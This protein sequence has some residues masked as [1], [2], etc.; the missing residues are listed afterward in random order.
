[1]VEGSETKDTVKTPKATARGV[2][3]IQYP[4]LND[5][6]YGLWAVK[7]KIILRSLG[8]WGAIEGPEA[9]EEDK[10]HG[11]LAAISQAVP[12]PVMMAIA[13]KDSAKEAWDAIKE[14]SVG[15][16]RVRKARA[17]ALKRQFDGIVMEDTT[18]VHEFSQRLTSMA[19]EIRSLGGELKDS[20]IIERLF[21]A[22]PDKFL[23]II[24]TIEQWGDLTSMSVTEAVGR[25][26]VFEESLKGRRQHKEEEEHVL[27]TRAQ[28][29]ALSKEKKG[30]ESSGGGHNQGQVRGHEK[31]PQRKFDKSKIR[32]YN[33]SEYGHFASECRKPKKEKAYVAEKV[34]D[35]PVLLMLEACEQKN[36]KE[37]NC[38]DECHLEKTAQYYKEENMQLF[39]GVNESEKQNLWYLDSGATNHMTGC[40]ENFTELDTS[41]AGTVKFGDGSMVSIY[42]RGTVLLQGRMGE[43]KALTD[44][45]Y[46]PKL[47]SNIISLGQLEEQGCRIMLENGQLKV[48][49]REEQLLI[50]VKRARNRL[51]ILNL[52]VTQPICLKTHLNNEDWLWHARYGHLNFQALRTLSQKELVAGLPLVNHAEQVCSGCLVGKQRRSPFPQE[53]MFRAKEVLELVHGDLCGPIV[54]MTPAGNKFFLLMVDDYSR[55]MWIVLLKSKDMAFQAFKEIKIAAELEANAKLKAFRT[56]RGGEFRS[57]EFTSYCKQVGIKRYL[58]A[59]YSPQQ[60]GVVERRNQTVVGMAR[61]M[62]RS[63]N[64]PAKFWGEAVTTAVYILNRAITKSVVGMTP[65]EAWHKQK[66]SVHHMRTFGCIA[67][68]KQLNNQGGKFAARSTPMVFIGYE[69]GSKAYRMYDPVTGKL[70]IS[71]DAVFEEEKAWNWNTVHGSERLQG[72]EMFEI[73]EISDNC[74]QEDEAQ[75]AF[76][77]TQSVRHAENG[78]EELTARV[79]LDEPITATTQDPTEDDVSPRNNIT[80]MRTLQDLYDVTEPIEIDYSELCLLG[81]EEPADFQEA[82]K[83]ESWRCAMQDELDSIHNNN[84][85]SLVDRPTDQKVIGL[86]W[87]YKVKKDSDGKVIKHKARLVAKGYVQKQGID[88]DE[89]FAPVARI[90]TVRLLIALAAHNGWK[91]H[92]MDVKSAFLNGELEEEVYVSQPPGFEKKG[93]EHKVLKLHKALYGLRQAPRAWNSKLD[94]TLMAIGFKRSPVEYAVYKKHC[95]QSFVFVGVYVDDLIITGTCEGEIS[96]FKEKMKEIFQMSD[97]GLLSYYLGIE[98]HQTTSNITLCQEAFARRILQSCGMEDCNMIQAPM[99]ARLKLSKKSTAPLVDQSKYRSIVGSLRYLLHT[100][101]DLAYSVGIVSRFMESPTTEHMNAVKHILRYIKGTSGL[102]CSYGKG[103]EEEL[104]LIGYS[105]SDLAGDLDDRK[106]TTGV[107]FFLGNNLIS[108]VS[109]KQ[110]VVALSSCEA[111]YIAAT[112]AACLGVWLQFLLTDL[113]QRKTGTVKLYIDNKSAIS[114]CKNPVYHDRTK[115]IDTRFHYIRECVEEKK[116]EVEHIGTKDQLADILTKPLGRIKFIEMRKRIGLQTVKHTQQ[117]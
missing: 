38:I 32:C 33:C 93:S 84:T 113:L 44:V 102:G 108:W 76:I 50:R 8:V 90:E 88:F 14:M 87:I 52:D 45:Y 98:V 89:V 41:V 43:H 51:Y 13:E 57:N 21:G 61:S 68:V 36:F 62:M 105:D 3:P 37:E 30:A 66:P 29:E 40:K 25:L 60:N 58:T 80:R 110:K 42:G 24:G 96:K 116:I 39:L 106:S 16:E 95:K 47:T 71:R 83:E 35:E 11:A 92:H 117:A 4:M 77:P 54:P 86:K 56:D 31:K 23:P 99:E 75:Q 17:Q 70:Q 100:R 69:I 6:N 111:E 22:V 34:E 67:H 15:E 107:A 73:Y 81:T 82:S 94:K 26:R 20:V 115:H 5:T 91:L 114:L 10:D 12:D 46:I 1:M 103:S 109:R 64:M 55:Y 59:P 104:K 27:L 49:D 2:V 48:F 74:E 53:A 7:M 85:W 78:T 97:L 65:Y 63:M 112:T 28:W 72:G 9:V 18:T 101:P 79:P 19:G